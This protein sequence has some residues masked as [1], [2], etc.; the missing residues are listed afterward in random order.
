MT[1]ALTKA[2]QLMIDEGFP[3]QL[4]LTPTDR[5]AAWKD[6]PPKPMGTFL[7]PKT[8][9]QKEIRAKIKAEEQRIRIAKLLAGQER[10]KVKVT[11]ADTRGMRWDSRHNK[12]VPDQPTKQAKMKDDPKIPQGEEAADQATSGAS[13]AWNKQTAEQAD[14]AKPVAATESEDTMATTKKKP[15]KAAKKV[16]K[17]PKAPKAPKAAKAAK[18]VKV[19]KAKA[20]KK[21]TSKAAR[22]SRK[23]IKRDGEKNKII[24]RMLSRTSGCSRKELLEALGWKAVSMQQVSKMVGL[25]LKIDKV[26]GKVMRYFGTPYASKK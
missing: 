12:F 14:P 4:L 26:P 16:A 11:K 18:P 3:S 25:K 5:D 22:P 6:K 15:A 2:Q 24:T 7:D 19:K 8:E 9:E 20:V 21:A 10:K 1:V 13:D 17:A 23:G